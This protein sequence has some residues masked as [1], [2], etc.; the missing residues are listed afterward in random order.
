MSQTVSSSSV[1]YAQP[2][3]FLAGSRLTGIVPNDLTPSVF[4]NDV[5]LA[6]PLEDGSEV[7][8]SAIQAGTVYFN[9]ISS[10]PGFY[11]LRFWVDRVGYWRIVLL[12]QTAGEA[13][14]DV[15]S[16]TPVQVPQIL[17]GSPA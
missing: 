16:S 7:P 13:S 15:S 3:F 11:S 2:D 1:A 12:H 17:Y 14:V 5:L 8:D 6:W 10:R 4:A 9:E